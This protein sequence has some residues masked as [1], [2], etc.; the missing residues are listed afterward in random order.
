MKAPAGRLKAQMNESM[1]VMKTLQPVS[2]K[3]LKPNTYILDM[4]QNMTGW[5][6][7][8]VKGNKGHCVQLTFAETLQQNGEL[9]TKNLRD[10]KKRTSIH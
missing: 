6:A 1:R 4:G 7:L 5:L 9:F 8:K 2:L 10:A 3:T